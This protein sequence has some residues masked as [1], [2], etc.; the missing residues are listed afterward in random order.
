MAR[1]CQAGSYGPRWVIVTDDDIDVTNLEELIWAALTRADPATSIDMI[2]C[3][4][5]AMS[6]PQ[7]TPWDRASGNIVNSRLIIDACKPF[8]W[9]DDF[10]DVNKPRP[11]DALEAR[12]KFGYLLD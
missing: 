8:H 1:T 4:V 9:R 10:P 2:K 7:L 6:D 11:E 3:G 12:E 5:G